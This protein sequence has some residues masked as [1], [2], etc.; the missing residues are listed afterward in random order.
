MKL[1]V[2]DFC[3]TLVDYQTADSF[4]DFVIEKEKYYHYEWLNYFDKILTKTRVMAVVRKLFPELNPSK[5]LKLFQIRGV[6]LKTIHQRAEE[7]YNQHLITNLITPVYKVL[8][9]HIAHN[10]YVMIIS[11]GYAPYIKVFSEK[12]QIKAFFAT[13]M[14][15][16]RNRL[17][18]S[19][20]GKD[21]LFGQ[22][23]VLLNQF[24]KENNIQ[25]TSSIAYSDSSSDLPL[26]QWAD[27]GVVI[28]KN[29]SQAWASQY[30]FQEI[31]HE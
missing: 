19:F 26:L 29:K 7:F 14:E 12:H 25:Y 15:S 13:E 28:S 6:A 23:V 21:C 18:G 22:K 3:E 31:I 17:T 30:G 16:T 24:L 1:V 9:A 20:L 27:E 10:D 2:F 5:R 8:N 11:G 4:V